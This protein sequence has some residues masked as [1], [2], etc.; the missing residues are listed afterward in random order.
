MPTLEQLEASPNDARP[1]GLILFAI[2]DWT[3]RVAASDTPIEVNGHTWQPFPVV[4]PD[5]VQSAE[6][7]KNDLTLEVPA[8]FPIAQLWAES[9]PAGT[10]LCILYEA[11]RGA[12]NTRD[13]WTGHVANVRFASAAKAEIQLTSGLN[14]LTQ[15]GLRQIAQRNCRHGIYTPGCGVSPE[16]FK[17]EAVVTDRGGLWIEAAEFAEQPDGYYEGGFIRWTNALGFRDWR[18]VRKHEGVRLT[19]AWSPGRLPIGAELTAHPGCDETPNH[20]GPKFNN[21]PNYG[22]LWW[23]KTKN[24]FES[25][26]I[27]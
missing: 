6:L 9:P 19:L 22:G 25:D 26:P 14:A 5:I 21:Q 3:L 8:T 18:H 2:D 24:P 1:V 10:M 16:D 11:D 4:M 12:S 17:T 27:Y 15:P 23:M 20:C 7:R 13:S